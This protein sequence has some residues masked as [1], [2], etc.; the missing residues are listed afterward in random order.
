MMTRGRWRREGGEAEEVEKK[1][2]VDGFKI[3]RASLAKTM[4]EIGQR[5]PP[6]V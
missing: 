3:L 6:I 4:V 1:K 2:L 5:H